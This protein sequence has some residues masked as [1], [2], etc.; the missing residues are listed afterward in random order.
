MR[1]HWFKMNERDRN[2]GR[3]RY[4]HYMRRF[5]TVYNKEEQSIFEGHLETVSAR[6]NFS[7][8]SVR[9]HIGNAGSETPWDGH[10]L[11]FGTGFFWGHSGFRKLAVRLSRCSDTRY[12]ARDW[13]LR[14]GDNRLWWQFAAH[15]DLCFKM[16]DGRRRRSA[17]KKRRRNTWRRGNI[18]IS[19][20]EA[21]WGPKRYTYEDIDSYPTTIKMPE[22]E[23]AV[24]I[25]LQKCFLGRT[26][27]ARRKHEVSWVLDVDSPKGVPTHYDPSGGWKGDR[28]YGWGVAFEYPRSEGWELDAE[29]AVTAWVLK[30]RARTGFRKP[31]SVG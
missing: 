4:W 18:N 2:G 28:T 14:I 8:L 10:I 24:V 15:D 30:E 31:Q 23:Y 16:Q 20:P 21:I 26:K 19:I 6:K 11:I 1:F 29:A 7:P 9:F 25:K 12:D 13:S 3:Q 27:V 17:F 22:G 5:L